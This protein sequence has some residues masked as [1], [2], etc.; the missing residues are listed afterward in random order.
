MRRGGI[1][2]LWCHPRP[3]IQYKKDLSILDTIR[4]PLNNETLTR[5][6]PW[7]CFLFN[8][9]VFPP[10]FWRSTKG[11]MVTTADSIEDPLERV[12]YSLQTLWHTVLTSLILVDFPEGRAGE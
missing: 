6:R 4:Y 3:T 9:P 1:F 11:T 2:T 10:V 7:T 5:T 12:S 8:R